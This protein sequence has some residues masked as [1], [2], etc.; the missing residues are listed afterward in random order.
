MTEVKKSLP[1]AKEKLH[2]NVSFRRM[3]DGRRIAAK[4]PRRKKKKT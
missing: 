2:G 1:N 3:K 4:W